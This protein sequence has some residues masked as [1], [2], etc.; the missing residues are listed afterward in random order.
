MA[1]KCATKR[2]ERLIELSNKGGVLEHGN[3][4]VLEERINMDN[5]SGIYWGARYLLVETALNRSKIE[6]TNQRFRNV[7]GIVPECRNE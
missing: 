3:C 1:I 5:A 6:G 7:L 4:N 2:N